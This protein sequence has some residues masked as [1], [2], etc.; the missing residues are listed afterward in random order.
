[1]YAFARDIKILFTVVAGEGHQ[2]EFSFGEIFLPRGD[3]LCRKEIP[4]A[5]CSANG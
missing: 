3:F 5:A 4:I 1:M 2:A